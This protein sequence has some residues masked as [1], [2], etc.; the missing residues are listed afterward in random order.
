MRLAGLSAR[1]GLEG[2]LSD[3]LSCRRRQIGSYE[4]FVDRNDSDAR[5]SFHQGAHRSRIWVFR[6]VATDILD[7]VEGAANLDRWEQLSSL[8]GK[9]GGRCWNARSP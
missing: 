8:E 2:E 9:S 6:G 7:V 4:Q 3:D 5:R 1:V